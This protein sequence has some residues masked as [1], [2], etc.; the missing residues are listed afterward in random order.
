VNVK[1]TNLYQTLAPR[2]RWHD[3]ETFAAELQRVADADIDFRGD[4][5]ELMCAFTWNDSPQGHDFWSALNRALFPD[6]VA[7]P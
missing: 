6:G 7:L 5:H 2:I 4:G 1:L 3:R